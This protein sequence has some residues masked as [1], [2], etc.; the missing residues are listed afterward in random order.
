MIR[1]FKGPDTAALACGVRGRRFGNIE[2]VARRVL[3]PL[4][5]AGRLDDLKVP[6]GICLEAFSVAPGSSAVASTTS[7]GKTDPVTAHADRNT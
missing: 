4:D 7:G 1:S 5:T 2:T 3:R 6:P